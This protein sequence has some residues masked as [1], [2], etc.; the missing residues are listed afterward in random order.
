MFEGKLPKAHFAPDFS[1]QSA[2]A[3]SLRQMT[4]SDLRARLEAAH[5]LH[6]AMGHAHEDGV[7]SFDAHHARHIAALADSKQPVNPD[8]LAIGKELGCRRVTSSDDDTCTDR[9]NS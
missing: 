7:A 1:Q 6:A 4:W 9:G 2:R 3:G 8:D 5:D